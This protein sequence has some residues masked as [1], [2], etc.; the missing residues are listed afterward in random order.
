MEPADTPAAQPAAPA[1]QR[2]HPVARWVAGLLSPMSLRDQEYC[3]DM[4]QRL[5]WGSLL[6]SFP[7]AYW[8]GNILV[9]VGGVCGATVLCLVLFVPNWYQHPDPAMKYAD[10]TEV[11]H[12]YQQY[13][14]AKKAA[15]ERAASLATSEQKPPEKTA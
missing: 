6:V 8:L 14:A 10:D 7:V 15:R 11:Y 9:T 1:P 12:Y 5:L 3:T 13:E 2:V 4:F